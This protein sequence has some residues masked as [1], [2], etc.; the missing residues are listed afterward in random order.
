VKSIASLLPWE[1]KVLPPCP[2]ASEGYY[3]F[4]PSIHKEP[5]GKLLCVVRC[6]D[7][8]R[9]NGI[10]QLRNQRVTTRNVML[11]LEP[12]TLEVIGMAEML[13]RDGTLRAQTSLT[14]GYEDLRL[15][16]TAQDGL[17][18]IATTL[19]LRGGDKPEMALLRLDEV[20]NYNIIGAVP[21]R[22]TFPGSWSDS[23]QKN[24]APFDGADF[25]RFL[26]SIERGV[27]F[28]RTGP[29]VTIN[30]WASGDLRGGSQLVPL[31]DGRWLGIAHGVVHRMDGSQRVI[32]RYWHVWYICDND[33]RLIARSTP[34]KLAEKG[35]ELAM[36]LVI[37]PE[38]D[39]VVVSYG[40]DDME[41]RLGITSLSTVL[42]MVK[43][44]HG[45]KSDT[46]EAWAE[47][48]EAAHNLF[49]PTRPRLGQNPWTG[50]DLKSAAIH[51]AIRI[52]TSE[53]GRDQE[54]MRALECELLAAI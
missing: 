40:V 48:L 49:D 14:T 15:F 38:R 45:Y 29:L 1:E 54:E 22:G 35:I 27:L 2:F 7:Y 43:P 52:A 16:R 12:T 50:R 24:W 20:Y 21:I 23:P 47:V 13:E 17:L 39:R 26:Y 51:F 30:D 3:A 10:P 32:P 19:Q 4:N 41:A 42:D 8:C 36:G 46:A 37:N 28:G 31:G 53:A 33:G 6:A 11:R 25:A 34:M 44:V 5:D 18:A 9:P